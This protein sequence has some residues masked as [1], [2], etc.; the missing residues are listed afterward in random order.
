MLYS[1]RLALAAARRPWAYGRRLV[2]HASGSPGKPSSA[3]GAARVDTQKVSTT[4]CTCC[5]AAC[6]ADAGL[7]MYCYAGAV[8]LWSCAAV[9]PVLVCFC[10]AVLLYC[11]AGVLL[12]SY[13][14]V[15]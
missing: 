8:L 14:P 6:T 10:A 1:S 4:W 2:R 9:L 11:C 5:T 12:C 3:T 7:L 15:L 13:A